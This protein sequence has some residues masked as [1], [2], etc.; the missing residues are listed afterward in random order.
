MADDTINVELY[1][2]VAALKGTLMCLLVEQAMQGSRD[3]AEQRQFL[4]DMRDTVIRGS[5]TTA[6]FSNNELAQKIAERTKAHIASIFDNI[7]L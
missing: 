2:S 1:A 6:D 7:S 5:G 4:N 3:K